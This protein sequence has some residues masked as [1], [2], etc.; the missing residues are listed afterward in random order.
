MAPITSTTRASTVSPQPVAP[1]VTL[2]R[3]VKMQLARA[4]F[5]PGDVG[6]GVTPAFTAALKAFQTAWGL[7]ASGTIDAKTLN[8]LRVTGERIAAHARKKDGYVSVGQKSGAIKTLEQRLARLGYDVGAADGIYSRQTADA[9]R[10]FKADQR[11]LAPHAASG[12]LSNKSRAVLKQEV[13][14]VAHAP[15]RARVRA[16][17]AL[18]A[19]DRRTSV[20]ASRGVSEGARGGVVK[21]L[22]KHL[23]AAGFDPKHTGG[24]FDERT[25]GAVKNFQRKAGLPVTGAVDRAT[26]KALQKSYL[27]NAKAPQA[28]GE[29]S[30]LVKRSERWLQTLGFKPGKADGLFS[31][32][33]QKAVRAFEKKQHLKVDGKISAAEAKKLQALANKKLTVTPNM[34]RLAR[35]A[36][37]TALSMGGYGGLGLCATGVSRSI[38]KTWG[39]KVWGNGNQIDNNLPRSHF[40]QVKLPL[41]KALKIPGLILTWEKTSTRLGSI[42]G[43]TAITLGDG[44][45][46]ASD[47]IETNTLAGNASRRG[48]KIFVPIK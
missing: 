8:K 38:L 16:S 20:A 37:A 36:K 35:N 13:A 7:S 34:R 24:V 11:E 9:V 47:F 15:E 3:G 5:D 19:L 2:V 26:W 12:A 23:K 30:A 17:S 22:Q 40:K 43:H 4:G 41:A 14:A 25:A 21:N 42:Y 18:A 6:G 45:S 28:L 31:A 32:A 1:N 39:I 10:R 33:T 27:L 29:R 46:S 44:H 48:L